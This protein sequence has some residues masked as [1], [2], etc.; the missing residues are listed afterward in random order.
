MGLRFIRIHTERLFGARRFNRIAVQARRRGEG[1][2]GAD[3]RPW[4]S[5]RPHRQHFI[6]A[7][8]VVLLLRFT[9]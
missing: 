6:D 3:S 7:A 2:I 5:V 8:R 4:R 9:A 1:F